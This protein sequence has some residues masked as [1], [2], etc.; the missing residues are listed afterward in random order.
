MTKVILCDID[1]T[2]SD[3]WKRIRRNTVPKWPGGTIKSDAFGRTEVMKDALLPYCHNVL[4]ELQ[5]NGFYIRYLTA[6]GWE[7]ATRITIEQLTNWGLPNPQ[8]VI[9]VRNMKEKL[10]VVK[11]GICK[12]VIDDFMT[13]QENAIGTLHK[14][15]AETMQTMGINIIVFRNDWLDVLEQIRIY[16]NNELKPI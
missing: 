11:T 3:H 6:R 14:D 4:W 2:L 7:H 5:N 9:L 13:G 1:S 12:Y 15:I 16:E 8:D 10:D